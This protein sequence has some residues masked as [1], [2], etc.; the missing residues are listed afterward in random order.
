MQLDYGLK[1]QKQLHTLSIEYEQI[2][3][4]SWSGEVFLKVDQKMQQTHNNILITL[5]EVKATTFCSSEHLKIS[6]K[7]SWD[8]IL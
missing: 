8:K 7:T 5:P 2:S 4:R 1:C 3:T 6:E